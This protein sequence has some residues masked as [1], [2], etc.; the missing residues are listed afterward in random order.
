[1]VD[2]FKTLFEFD[3]DSDEEDEIPRMPIARRISIGVAD[4]CKHGTCYAHAISRVLTRYF[5][6]Q[7][8]DLE[9]HNQA[10]D[11]A[12]TRLQSTTFLDRNCSGV[13]RTKTILYMLI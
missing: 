4:Q 1:M 11:D 3:S 5:Y 8:A 7:V 2:I 13:N 12:I 10:C 6:A 9:E